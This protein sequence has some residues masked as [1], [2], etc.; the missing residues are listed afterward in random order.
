MS[1]QMVLLITGSVAAADVL[2]FCLTYAARYYRVKSVRKKLFYEEEIKRQLADGGGLNL[3]NIKPEQLMRSF[4]TLENEV[5]LSQERRQE[6]VNYLLESPLVDTYIRKLRS[7]RRRVRA[8]SAHN[9]KYLKGKKVTEA[10]LKALQRETYPPVILHIVDALAAQRD[11]GQ[12]DAGQRDAGKRDAG[13]RVTKAIPLAVRKL[14]T[15]NPWYAQ[16]IQAILYTYNKD[17]LRYARTRL[18][19]SR[20]YMQVLFCGFAVDYPAEELRGMLVQRAWSKHKSVNS[21]AIKALLKHFPQELLKPP[22]TESKRR[23]IIEAV[24]TAYGKIGGKQNITRILDYAGIPAVHDEIVQA[25]SSMAANEPAV[26]YELLR[27]FSTSSD[28]RI[29]GLLAKVLSNRIEYFLTRIHTSLEERV[30]SLV[31]QLVKAKHISGILVF[32]NSNQDSEI[33]D[34]LIEVLQKQMASSSYLRSEIRYY[35]HPEIL[36]KFQMT[37]PKTQSLPLPHQ[38]PPS[39]M[40]LIGF[41]AAVL[42][43]FPLII[44]GMEFRTF[45]E[46]GWQELV[47]LYVVRFNYLFVFYSVAINSIYLIFLGISLYAAHIQKQLWDIKDKQLLFTRHLLPAVSIIAPAYNEAVSIIESTNSLLNQ[48]YPDYELIIVNDG[49]KDDTLNTLIS[50]Y[51]LEKQDKIVRYRLQ[52]R[53]LRGIYTNRHIPNLIVVDKFNGG[54]ADSLNLGINISSKEFFCGIDADSLLEPDA[55]LKAVSVMLDTPEESFAAGGNIYPVNGCTVEH[56]SLEKIALPDSFLPRL[57]TLEYIRSFM[58]GRVGWAYINSLLII[59]GAFGIFDREFS[60]RSGG[61]LTKSGKYHKDTVGEDM[62]LVVRITRQLRELNRP[63]RVD[64]AFHSNCWTEVPETWKVL[65]RQRDRWHRGLIDIML[66]HRKL[67]GNPRYGRQGMIGMLYF[68]LFELVG[69]FVE[70]KGILMVAVSILIGV[71]N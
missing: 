67:I 34:K 19:S 10:L 31:S 39:R 68:F 11:A 53:R 56:G 43:M 41:L 50:Y 17:F 64:Y 70:S 58:A 47:T 61:Y 24:I 1:L 12:R 6:I 3:E 45:F 71:I 59:S 30:V 35:L 69:P 36:K 15:M 62:E 46:L 38:D 28:K 9:L 52:T 22:F 63:Y 27:L 37:E 66:F 18:M 21:L 44:F 51:Q 2:M 23:D 65:H 16:R 40:E 42:A 25:L 48:Q 33:E 4:I 20:I 8:E 60:I 14:R 29:K 32:L 13:K 5:Q 26:L 7:Y 49:S 54:K 57:Q 55:L